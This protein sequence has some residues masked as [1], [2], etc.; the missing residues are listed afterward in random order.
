MSFHSVLIHNE[1]KALKGKYNST[2]VYLFFI[3]FITFLAVGFAKSALTYQ[4]KLSAA[5]FSNW[6]NLNY[7]AGT[8]DS[9][10]S[11][12][13]QI[14]EKQFRE[15]FHIQGAYFYNKGMVSVLSVLHGNTTVQYEARTIDP[16]SG[17]V[18]DLLHAGVCAKYFPDSVANV[19]E[20][21]PNG[22]IISRRLLDDI[23]LDKRSVSFIQI[24]SPVGDLVPV[25]VLAVVNELPDLSDIVYTNLFYCK[26][27]N[28]GFY[29]RD[30]S[31]DRIFVENMDTAGI[32]NVL[33]ELY[34]VLEIRD[35]STV[36]TTVLKTGNSA[37]LNWKIEIGTEQN[38][39]PGNI[40][41]EKIANLNAL[42]NHHFGQYFELSKD[43]SCD[44]SA[45]FHDYLAIEFHDLE[46]IREFST[47]L[48]EQLTLQLNLEVL[49]DRENYLFTGNIAIGSIMLLM[50]LSVIS[51]SIYI[52]GIIRNHLLKMKKNLGN[53]LA[54]GV[55]NTTLIRLY[56]W[57]TVKILVAAIV[58][59]FLVATA[60]GEFFEKYLLGK[61][62]VLD[63]EQD[64]FSLSDSWFAMFLLLILFVSVSRTFVSVKKILKHTPG[65]LIYERDS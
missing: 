5:P 42:K 46:R 10:R 23:G 48:K 65:D 11:L 15:R 55:K 25:P 56:I 27:M 21:E 13:E 9:L 53:F 61:L 59:A 2:I 62:L 1:F 39:L 51:V 63:A 20:Y 35:P 31:Y 24:K 3:L 19:F 64:Y 16:K 54:F 40:R 36:Q 50:V 38:D 8:R 49:S 33:K 29:D 30:N 4:Q 45:F 12:K 32:L 58:P 6:V 18:K 44:N 34:A 60:T 43:S 14:S 47:Y 52:S 7:H 37:V 41:K 28:T 26:T 22:V 17:I 57:V